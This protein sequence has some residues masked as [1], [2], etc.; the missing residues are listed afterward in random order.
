MTEKFLKALS[1]L[2]PISEDDLNK[3]RLERRTMSPFIQ[4]YRCYLF[5]NK[6]IQSC[7]Y[8]R[9]TDEFDSWMNGFFAAE[10]DEAFQT[11]RE[12]YGGRE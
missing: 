3:L 6:D 9:D 4:G 8:D 12:E 1:T 5:N 2:E 10:V 7:P 11:W